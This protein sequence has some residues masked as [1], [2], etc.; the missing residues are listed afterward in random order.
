MAFY[1]LPVTQRSIQNC[2]CRFRSIIA[3]EPERDS[4][5]VL[6]DRQ[7]HSHGRNRPWIG[8]FVS[9]AQFVMLKDMTVA[10]CSADSNETCGILAVENPSPLSGKSTFGQ[11]LAGRKCSTW[12]LP[13]RLPKLRAHQRQ[14][15]FRAPHPRFELRILHRRQH[16]SECRPRLV[17]RRDQIA[18][19]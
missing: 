8:S 13:T 9:V 6:L 1:S 17:A 19:G 18:P 4:M 10:D 5:S 11:N 16:L 2:P 14:R 7:G 15:L 12:G 3:G